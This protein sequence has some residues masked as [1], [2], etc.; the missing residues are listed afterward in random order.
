[1]C[2][3]VKISREYQIRKRHSNVRRVNINQFLE[4]KFENRKSK[5]WSPSDCADTAGVY[6]V[7]FSS[8]LAS[9][10]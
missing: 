1:M 5:V 10:E 7:N 9:V 3:F 2:F 6:D 8:K 4:I